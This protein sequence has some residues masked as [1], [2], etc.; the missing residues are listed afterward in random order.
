VIGELLDMRRTWGESRGVELSD[1]N[2]P[3]RRVLISQ[4]ND[5]LTCQGG[6]S[7]GCGSRGA[8]AERE[9]PAGCGLALG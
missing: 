2:T 8:V 1:V 3:T 6:G 9:S 7:W 5:V 4:A